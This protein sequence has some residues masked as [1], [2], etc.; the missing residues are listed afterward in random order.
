MCTHLSI[1]V[2]AFGNF[3]KLINGQVLFAQH[4]LEKQKLGSTEIALIK[5]L[6]KAE[7]RSPDVDEIIHNSN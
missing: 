4:Y 6:A 1:D 2:K 5:D 3:S 7:H